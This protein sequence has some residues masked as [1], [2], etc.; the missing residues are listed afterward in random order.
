MSGSKKDWGHGKKTSALPVKNQDKELKT[1]RPAVRNR[2]KEK[3]TPM[4]TPV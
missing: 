1:K 2:T 3:D 4:S